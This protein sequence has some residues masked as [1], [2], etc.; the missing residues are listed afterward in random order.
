MSLAKLPVIFKSS[1]MNTTHIGFA[2][3]FE[4]VEKLVIAQ[5]ISASSMSEVRSHADKPFWLVK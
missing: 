4:E 2:S 3:S 5:H 1:S